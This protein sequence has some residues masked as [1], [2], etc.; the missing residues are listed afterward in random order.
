MTSADVQEEAEEAK[1]GEEKEEEKEEV[2]A[3]RQGQNLEAVPQETDLPDQ[4]RIQADVQQPALGLHVDHRDFTL[5]ARAFHTAPDSFRRWVSP[6]F[7]SCHSCSGCHSIGVHM[8]RITTESI[9]PQLPNRI[10]LLTIPQIQSCAF[11]RIIN[12]V[13]VT[14]LTGHTPCH[15]IPSMP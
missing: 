14:T 2:Q 1:E 5:G 12:H 6:P 15:P 3:V 10:I 11:V 7:S 13:G 8:E 9:R 4:R